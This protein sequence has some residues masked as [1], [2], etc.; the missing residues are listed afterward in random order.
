[1]KAI[2][3]IDI[4]E[5]IE[6]AYTDLYVNYDLRGTPKDDTGV[7]ESIKYVEEASLKPMPKPKPIGDIEEIIWDNDTEVGYNCGWNACLEEI[8]K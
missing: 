4:P 5:D 2:L 8:E 6:E 3:V 7:V 1:M